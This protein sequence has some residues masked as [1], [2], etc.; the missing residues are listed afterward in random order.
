MRRSPPFLPKARR[1]LKI[2]GASSRAGA[3]SW[4]PS[5]S[6]RDSPF[7]PSRTAPSIS[8]RTAAAIRGRL[9]GNCWSE[10]RWPPRPGSTLAPTALIAL[11]A[12]P[13]REAWTISRTR[14]GGLPGL[15]LAGALPDRLQAHALVEHLGRVARGGLVEGAAVHLQR[16]LLVAEAAVVLAEDL[17]ADVD[18][19]LGV[20]ERFLAAVV[21][22]LLE[23]ELRH[24]LHQSLRPHD[25]FGHRVVA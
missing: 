22:Q 16:G 7:H 25:A 17:R 23:V 12:S 15:R 4:C 10:R 6:G 13:T 3:I 14:L 8:T 20:E 24:D 5:S 19:H 2:G 18:V 9:R 1:S 11:Y 21:E